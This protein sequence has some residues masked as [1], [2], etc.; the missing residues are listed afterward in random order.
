[1]TPKFSVSQFINLTNQTLEFAYPSVQ[2]VGE[3]SSFKVNQDKYVFFDLKDE[4]ASV[5]CFMMLWQLR[6]P[7]QDGMKVIVSAKPKLTQWGKFS[8]T[9]D[10]FSLSGEGDIKKSLELLRQKLAREGL[11]DISR[12][13]SLPDDIH[14]IA[15][16]SSKTA[17]GWADFTKILNERWGGLEVQLANVQVQGE[18]AA[19]QIIRAISYFNSQPNLADVLVLIRGGGS[20]QDLMAFN[21]ELLARAIAA[22]R[23]PVITGIGHEIDE[24]LADLTADVVASTPSN[25]AQLITRDKH[26]ETAYIDSAIARL[27]VTIIKSLNEALNEQVSNANGLGQQLIQRIGLAVNSIEQQNKLIEQLNPENVLKRGYA[28]LTGKLTL[29]D[30]VDITTYDKLISAEVKH[31]AKR[32]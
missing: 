2:V 21:D 11:F 9:V 15:V 10:S 1:M 4:T 26:A 20:R 6:T 18:G 12:K 16:V 7:L 14:K 32:R 17:A 23:L 28:L 13:R 3:V 30:V 29:G 5:N 24:S 31:V 25:A 19:D 8:L 27:S 22:S